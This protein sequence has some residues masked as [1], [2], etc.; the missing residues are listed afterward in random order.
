MTTVILSVCYF[1]IFS[2]NYYCQKMANTLSPL[3]KGD[4]DNLFSEINGLLETE[5][6]KKSKPGQ[7]SSVAHPLPTIETFDK[8]AVLKFLRLLEPN[9]VIFFQ[10]IQV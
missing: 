10:D 4:V 5:E 6:K 1:Y 2:I 3:S 8:D 7:D 9:S